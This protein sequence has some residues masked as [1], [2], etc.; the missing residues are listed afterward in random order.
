MVLAGYLGNGSA[1]DNLAPTFILI[2]F[3]V[4]LV[5][6]SVLFGD[7]FRAFSPWRAIRL[8][9]I[10]PYPER[11]GRY[12]AALALLVFTWIELVSGWGEVPVD[13]TNAAVGYTVY[14][15]VM[16][17]IFGTETWTRNGE[18][19][20]VYFNLFS[21]I[22]IWETRDRVVGVR[23]PLGGLPRLPTPPGT[24][25]FVVVMIGTVT[26]DGF[27]QGQIW[28]DFSVDLAGAI[29]GIVGLDAA[30]K[31][32]GTLGLLAA[33]AVI[34]GFYRL[35]IDGARSVGGELDAP[36]LRRAF[37]HTLVPIALVYVDRPLPDVPAVRGPG[38]VLPRLGPVRRGLGPVRHRRPRDQLH[39]PE[40]E[41]DLVRA[42]R[43][44]RR[45]ARR[46]AHARPRPRAR[47]LPRPA[48]GRALAVLDAR[49]DGRL[50]VTGAVAARPGRGVSSA[51]R[52]AVRSFAA[53]AS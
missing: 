47:A 1:L 6:A 35:G 40:P 24:V 49:R 10:R 46:G 8:P 20:A 44:R 2:D 7:V 39:V 52:P 21:R 13:L 37:I 34:G 33:V 16:Q 31:V 30:P 29:D 45:R 25:L 38:D 32:V 28:K 53:E 22:S 3:W 14:T 42:G 15:L 19:F 9:G 41:R 23:P 36:E 18:A 51:N 12:P 5:F 17:A 4:G 43:G 27:S 48:P 11:W 50:H 26:F